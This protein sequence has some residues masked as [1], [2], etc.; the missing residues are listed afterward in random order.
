MTHFLLLVCFPQSKVFPWKILGFYLPEVHLAF[1]IT[2]PYMCAE[3]QLVSL[4][5]D[6]LFVTPSLQ[7]AFFLHHL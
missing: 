1:W 3:I 2:L 6:M 7:K 4:D 5:A